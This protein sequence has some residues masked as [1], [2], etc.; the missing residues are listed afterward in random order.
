MPTFKYI[1]EFFRNSE[2]CKDIERM[3]KNN[4]VVYLVMFYMKPSWPT[5]GGEK[6]EPDEAENLGF[7]LGSVP[8]SHTEKFTNY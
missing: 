7:K 4:R 3:E 5:N 8:H 2:I 1:P 6:E